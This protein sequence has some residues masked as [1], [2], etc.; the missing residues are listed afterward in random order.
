[1]L[2][3][4]KILDN[5]FKGVEEN[6]KRIAR[7]SDEFLKAWEDAFAKAKRL[8]DARYES[9]QNKSKD[10]FRKNITFTSNSLYQT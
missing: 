1:M 5:N 10:F 9:E 7:V 8:I 2:V 6:K 4:Q 3:R